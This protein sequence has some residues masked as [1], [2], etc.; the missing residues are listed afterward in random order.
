[1]PLSRARLLLNVEKLRRCALADASP[2]INHLNLMTVN[3]NRITSPQHWTRNTEQTLFSARLDVV[4]SCCFF[5]LLPHLAAATTDCSKWIRKMVFSHIWRLVETLMKVREWKG[6]TLI[7]LFPRL[8][9]VST[10]VCFL[11]RNEIKPSFIISW[12]SIKVMNRICYMKMAFSLS[13]HSSSTSRI[14]WMTNLRIRRL[15][16]NSWRLWS[17]LRRLC[18]LYLHSEQQRRETNLSRFFNLCDFDWCCFRRKT[19]SYDWKSCNPFE[20][21]REKGRERSNI[22]LEQH[23][24]DYNEC[25]S[26][27]ICH[28]TIPVAARVEGRKKNQPRQQKIFAAASRYK[29]TIIHSWWSLRNCPPSSPFLAPREREEQVV[30]SI[31]HNTQHNIGENIKLFNEEERESEQASDDRATT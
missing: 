15:F 25:E 1:M 30:A 5:F 28:N 6:K 12:L 7:P 29:W 11:R 21:R 4:F 14:Q 17:E 16:G 8:V 3:I 13:S 9:C 31:E 27:G 26:G 24:L 18:R 10:V 20:A 2:G 23:Q 22:S 19:L